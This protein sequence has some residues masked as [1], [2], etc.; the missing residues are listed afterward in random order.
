ML[1]KTLQ[2]LQRQLYDLAHS[3]ANRAEI[4]PLWSFVSFVVKEV[5]GND[6]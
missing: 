2:T 3:K 5:Y 1:S 6:T 4:I